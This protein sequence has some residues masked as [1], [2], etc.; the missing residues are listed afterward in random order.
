M[1]VQARGSHAPSSNCLVEH[2]FG[3]VCSRPY[4]PIF[5]IMGEDTIVTMDLC[6]QASCCFS[7]KNCNTGDA[8]GVLCLFRIFLRALNRVVDRKPSVCTE[9]FARVAIDETSVVK[10]DLGETVPIMVRW[11]VI[12][13]L[14]CLPRSIGI[15]TRCL[16]MTEPFSERGETDQSGTTENTFS[17]ISLPNGASIFSSTVHRLVVMSTTGICGDRHR[18]NALAGIGSMLMDTRG[19]SWDKTFNPVRY[20]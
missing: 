19:L 11:S 20:R 4:K 5:Y 16:G 10:V 3:I 8:L 9:N 2:K 13:E 12:S 1:K 14:R 6:V 7:C 18:D 15:D 17:R